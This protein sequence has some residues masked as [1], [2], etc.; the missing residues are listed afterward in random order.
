MGDCAW[1]I[2]CFV[3][4]HKTDLRILRKSQSSIV[5]PALAW[6]PLMPE[7]RLGLLPDCDGHIKG[8]QYER[9]PKVASD[10]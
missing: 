8:T 2:D 10:L 4:S 7:G 6:V 5:K 1:S 9:A 3:A